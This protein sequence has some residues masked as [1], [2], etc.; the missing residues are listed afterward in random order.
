MNCVCQIQLCVIIHQ[1]HNQLVPSFFVLRCIAVSKYSWH[2]SDSKFISDFK[3]FP[4]IILRQLNFG[5]YIACLTSILR[6]F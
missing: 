3:T 4:I 6:S 5:N 1:I 2:K